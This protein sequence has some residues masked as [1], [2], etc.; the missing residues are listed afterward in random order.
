MIDDG[1]YDNDT[2]N[3]HMQIQTLADIPNCTKMLRH[4]RRNNPSCEK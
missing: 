4:N 1:E 2:M 3:A